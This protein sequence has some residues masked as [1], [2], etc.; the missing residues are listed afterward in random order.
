MFATMS[1]VNQIKVQIQK[2]TSTCKRRAFISPKTAAAISP[3][4]KRDIKPT[5]NKCLI[6]KKHAK[7]LKTIRDRNFPSSSKI[8]SLIHAHFIHAISH[9][10][11]TAGSDNL[12]MNV[13]VLSRFK[14]RLLNFGELNSN[15]DF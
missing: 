4:H 12:I 3:Q 10:A 8:L 15:H 6:N 11:G 5:K 7:Q 2:N 9:R 1:K 13:L 14:T